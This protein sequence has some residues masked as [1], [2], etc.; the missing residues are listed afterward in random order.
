MSKSSLH[1]TY[2][3]ICMPCYSNITN[4]F[5]TISLLCYRFFIF[6]SKNASL[7]HSRFFCQVS[8][9]LVKA[10]WI[11]CF[12]LAYL[13]PQYVKLADCLQ[14]CTPIL[15]TNQVPESSH[16]V[17]SQPVIGFIS[18]IQ[19]QS[20]TAHCNWINAVIKGLCVTSHNTCVALA[21]AAMTRTWHLALERRFARRLKLL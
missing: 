8:Y 11:S 3:D 12:P 14:K 7:A 6:Y 5:F 1:L 16:P 19:M 9:G 15:D 18:K 10:V 13:P 2:F 21:A 20:R 17:L 4:A